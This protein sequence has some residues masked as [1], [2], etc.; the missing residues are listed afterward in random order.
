[1]DFAANEVVIQAGV[2]AQEVDGSND[3]SR[4]LRNH[5]NDFKMYNVNVTNTFG[6]GIQA[7]AFSQTSNRVGLYACSF[8]GY[9]D[10]L[11]ANQGTQ[12]YLRGYIE[13]AVDFIFGR[14]GQAFFGG[15]TIAVKGPGFITA[16]GRESDDI[17][18]YVYDHNKIILAPDAVPGTAGNVFLGRP[19]GNFSKVIYKNTVVTA[20]LNSGIWSIWDVGD[21]RTN[22]VFFAEFNTMGPGVIGANRPSFSTLLNATEA[23]NFSISSAVGSDFATWVDLRY[24]V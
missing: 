6:P 4:S 18:S 24:L 21:E 7:I 22:H 2:N 16:N 12:V 17:G 5:K 1:M 3:A 13:G 20:P 23:K 19:W 11:L 10:T 8:I 15:N 14:L 9:Q